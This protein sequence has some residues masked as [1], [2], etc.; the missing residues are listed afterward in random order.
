[1]INSIEFPEFH[2]DKKLLEKIT[3]L[4]SQNGN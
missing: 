4:E 2:S 1:M 3:A